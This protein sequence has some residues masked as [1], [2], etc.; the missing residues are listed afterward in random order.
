M[1]VLAGLVAS[2]TVPRVYELGSGIRGRVLQ[3]YMSI[4][5]AERMREA[6]SSLELADHD[7]RAKAVL[8]A[9]RADFMRDFNVQNHN[10][11]ESGERA[12]VGDIQA[13]ATKLFSDLEAGP[14]DARYDGEFDGL[15]RRIDDLTAI[16]ES[17]MFRADRRALRI[18]RQLAFEFGLGLLVVFLSGAAIMVFLGLHL[19]KPLGDLARKLRLVSQRESKLRLGPQPLAELAV[20]AQ[21]FN[22]L[23]ERLEQ[24]DKLNVEQLLYEKGKTEAIIESLE[25]GVALIDPSG[26]VTH[27]N[28]IATII[29]G[30]EQTDTLGHQFGALNSR[31]PHYLR[32]RDALRALE[33][34]GGDQPRTEIQ[35]HVRGRDHSYVLKPI[36]LHYPGGSPL[37]TL[38]ILQDVTYLRDQDRAR[39]NLVATL[40]H[41]IKTPLTS[42]ALSAEMLSRDTTAPSPRQTLL[43][44]AILEEC[45]RMRQ[46][47]DNLL[48]L[49]RG[50]VPS[51]A[52]Q[53]SQLDLARITTDVTSR[54]GLQAQE[55]QVKL[56]S[57]VEPLPAM[58]GDPLKLSWVLSNLLGN[59]LRYTK[60]GGEIDVV[61]HR[62]GQIVRLEV[63][64]TGPGIA[65]ALKDYIFERFA[66]YESSHGERGSTGLGLAIVKDIVEAHGGRI[67]VESNDGHG[68]RFIVELPVGA[69]V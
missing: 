37:G 57:H 56:Q 38:L 53:R 68:S 47:T 60:A 8:P 34:A 25:D 2:I 19:W 24:Y 23:T 33:Q 5:A 55:K 62:D 63:A 61:A 29:M 58:I 20:V 35:L 4:Q 28:E 14:S 40:S 21:E 12:I 69:E 6:L 67:F 52:L 17:A 13:R 64:D 46:L 65:P 7:G 45:A 27:I 22:L 48:G 39:T 10:F 1:F 9:A 32:I 59:A 16:N 36:G 3:N 43:I 66:Q 42:L 54:F 44:G 26:K 50:E 51:I 11:A 31:H 41:E 15:A 49:A 18:S 30:V